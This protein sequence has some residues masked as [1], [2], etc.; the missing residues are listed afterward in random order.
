MGDTILLG[1]YL[2][3]AMSNLQKWTDTSPSTCLTEDA[4]FLRTM[5]P[6]KAF[7]VLLSANARTG[8]CTTAGA[9]VSADGVDANTRGKWLIHQAE[10]AGLDI[11]NGTGLEATSPCALTSF[12]GA[13]PAV[14]DYLLWTRDYLPDLQAR[15][16]SVAR[17]TVKRSDHAI[18]RLQFSTLHADRD[19]TIPS[20]VEMPPL[21]VQEAPAR[22][23]RPL[24]FLQHHR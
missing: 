4:S 8:Q 18:L 3:P 21:S 5:Y 15:A 11:L 7:G 6:E 10:R 17:H 22:M 9:R 1:A 16:F 23:E 2:F 20:V 12:Q 14:I 24:W 13:G 19:E